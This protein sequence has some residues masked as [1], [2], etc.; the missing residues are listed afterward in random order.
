M[1]VPVTGVP[2]TS[3]PARRRALPLARG[4]GLTHRGM[5]RSRNEDAILTDPEHGVLWV[6]ADGMGG[7]GHGDVA[8]DIVVEYLGAVADTPD[9]GAALAA[10][11]EAAN[12]AVL[13]RAR[14]DGLGQ[15][16]STVVALMVQR[17]V[18]HLAWVGD[19]RAYLLR[20]PRLRLVTRDHTVVQELVDR[21]ELTGAEAETHP[22]AH[23]VTRAVGGGPMI[24]V[25]R[26]AV[27]LLPGDRVLLCSDGLPRCVDDDRIAAR[28]TEAATPEAAC[29]AL[30]REALAN[31]SP[32]N[33]S[34]IV[35]DLTEA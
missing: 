4:A 29:E 23:I 16:G 2:I 6:V 32:D 7:Y 18:A 3:V 31:G 33:V 30:V 10:Q 35:I 19:A 14:R 13:D 25:A 28:L 34:V 24:D 27:P 8:S 5:V 20:G 11:I 21:G 17:A 1:T 12:R 15:M 9:P 22:E 26:E